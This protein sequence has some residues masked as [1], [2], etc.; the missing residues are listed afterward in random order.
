MAKSAGSETLAVNVY[1]QLR[2]AILNCKLVPGERLKP[3]ELG[4]GF[5]VSLGVMREALG[6]LA[7]QD[8][9]RIDRNRSCQV[10][11]LSLEALANLTAAR[12]ITEGAAL[13]RSVE[14]GGVTWESEVLA[15]HHRMAKLPMFLPE[16]PTSRNE[17]WALAHMGFHATLIENC[18]NPVLLDICA[19]L[20][21]AA[22]LYRAWSGLGTREIHRD[23]AGEHKALLDAALAHDADCSVTLFEAHVDRTQSLVTDFDVTA[24]HTVR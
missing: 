1:E 14:R 4:R 13:R 23:V 16:D 21:D 17:E 18:D 6:L 20:S 22:E 19:R 24:T 11:P 7:A 12:K 8:L 5:G 3:V 9:V 2:S 15:A 10:T